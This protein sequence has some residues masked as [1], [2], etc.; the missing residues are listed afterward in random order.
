GGQNGVFN[1]ATGIGHLQA[2]GDAGDGSEVTLILRPE[3]I[4]VGAAG[5]VGL[6]QAQIRE[7]VFQGD[8][9]R[10]LASSESGGQDF[11]LRLPPDARVEQGMELSLSCQSN[12]LVAVAR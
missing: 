4:L 8:H 6:G 2:V 11:V 10:V 7:A 9:Y 12:R 5:D 1:V 3:N